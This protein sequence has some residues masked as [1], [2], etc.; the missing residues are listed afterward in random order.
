[1]AVQPFVIIANPA[2]GPGVP[3]RHHPEAAAQRFYVREIRR[4]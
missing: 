1:M 2:E 4:R 3:D